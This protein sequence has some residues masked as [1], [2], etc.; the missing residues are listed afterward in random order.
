MSGL[1]SLEKE[2]PEN[3]ECPENYTAI[4]G[5]GKWKESQIAERFTVRRH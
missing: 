4:Y 2:V 5:L 3:L 1:S